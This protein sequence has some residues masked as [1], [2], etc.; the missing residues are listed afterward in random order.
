M[1][2]SPEP[3]NRSS[4]THMLPSFSHLAGWLAGWLASWLGF[5]HLGERAMALLQ[6]VIPIVSSFLSTKLCHP[7]HFTH[8]LLT[9]PLPTSP[10]PLTL[11]LPPL[12]PPGVAWGRAPSSARS[13]PSPLRPPPPR[14]RTACPAPTPRTRAGSQPWCAPRALPPWQL[15]IGWTWTVSKQVHLPFTAATCWRGVR[16]SP[17]RP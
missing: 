16:A 17:S 2:R 15:A 6:L 8:P 12:L 11:R 14:W 1:P 4:G 7:C 10:H 3:M 13:A 5:S 9:L